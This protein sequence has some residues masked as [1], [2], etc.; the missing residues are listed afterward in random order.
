MTNESRLGIVQ[1]ARRLA[2]L[3]STITSLDNALAATQRERDVLAAKNAAADDRIARL[4]AE[5]DAAVGANAGFKVEDVLAA[6]AAGV[7]GVDESKEETIAELLSKKV[8]TRDEAARIK[9]AMSGGAEPPSIV[10]RVLEAETT[11]PRPP[12]PVGRTPEAFVERVAD[13][14]SPFSPPES[15][16]TF[17]PDDAPRDRRGNV[18]PRTDSEL[19]AD[20]LRESQ[21]VRRASVA[22][23]GEFIF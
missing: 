2:A 13:L 18:T 6:Q 16:S 5:R 12:P 21:D 14:T 22:S 7:T 19:T 1:L 17:A 9:C 11:P 3:E 10:E 15:P 8:L 23:E 20:S 4:T